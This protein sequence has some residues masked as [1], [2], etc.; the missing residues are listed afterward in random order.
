MYRRALGEAGQ[1]A[2]SVEELTQAVSDAAEVFGPSSRMVGFYSLP[3]AES[4]V[5]T[6]QI[7]E[8][9]ET[10]ARRSRS[11]LNTPGRSLSDSGGHPSA[12]GRAPRGT[13]GRRSAARPDPYH[14]DL[15]QT[16]SAGH[17]V[18]RWYA[19]DQALA[20]ARAG[21]PSSAE[22][23]ERLLPKP[24]S[25]ADHACSKALYIMGVV[26]R[27]AGDASA[28]LGFQQQ[29]LQSIDESER[30]APSHE[31][32]DRDR[33]DAARS[34]QARTSRDVTRAC[35]DTVPPFAA[36]R[37]SDRTDIVDGLGAR[38]RSAAARTGAKSG[39]AEL[40]STATLGLRTRRASSGI[41][42]GQA[43]SAG[44]AF[45]SR[46]ASASPRT[47]IGIYSERR[48]GWA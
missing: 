5:E 17:V 28:S 29:A 33:A 6:G 41:E 21:G 34:R 10:A 48:G 15:R 19:A 30:R 3:L 44:P 31:G 23:I 14:R 1:P 4:Q 12:R 43:V 45:A 22:L 18:T 36:A 9:L 2:R 27:L 8:A 32:D 13:R 24:G 37:G 25:P 20:L 11:S 35:A 38:Q 26:K 7:A 40:M 16:F 47:A 46:C 42:G 39:A